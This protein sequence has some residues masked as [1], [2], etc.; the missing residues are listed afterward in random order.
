MKKYDIELLIVEAF[1]VVEFGDFENVQQIKDSY[2][3]DDI[4]PVCRKYKE[5]IICEELT[6]Q[7]INKINSLF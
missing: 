7:E 5:D 2:L 4:I 1:N 6:E 3:I